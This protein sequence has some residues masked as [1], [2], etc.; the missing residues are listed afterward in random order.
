MIGWL[1]G[2]VLHTD[3]AGLA[4]IDVN[5]VGYEAFVPLQTLCQIHVGEKIDLSIHTHVRED[6]ITLFGFSDAEERAL[7]RQ[8]ISVSGIGARMG[9]NILSGMSRQDLLNAVEAADDV[10]ISRIPGIGKKTA[11]RLILELKGKLVDGQGIGPAT[12]GIAADVRSALLNLG[13]KPA[14]TDK[15]LEA[16]ESGQ[17]FEATFKA[18]L[19]AMG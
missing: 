4:L 14:Q 11:Q 18:A 12:P 15:A 3:P 16:V 1:S 7:F 6:Q 10:V 2:T 13:Y 9:M 5:G 8:L 19:R 17:D